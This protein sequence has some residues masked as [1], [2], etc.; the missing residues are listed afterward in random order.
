MDIDSTNPDLNVI[1]DNDTIIAK[2]KPHHD[3]EENMGLMPVMSLRLLQ[4]RME[5]KSKMKEFKNDSTLLA[6]YTSKSNAL[7]V[8]ANSIY[9][10]SGYPYSPIY[11]RLVALSVTT[12]AKELL[13]K[14]VSYLES[15]KCKVIYGD[16][17]SVFYTIPE[18]NFADADKEYLI[19]KD[20]KKY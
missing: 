3:K 2:F 16:T 10:E 9:G 13:K 8:L 1:Y 5:A 11:E 15:L 7:K 17:D 4:D 18:D 14:V 6:Y 19:N 12:Y 20:K